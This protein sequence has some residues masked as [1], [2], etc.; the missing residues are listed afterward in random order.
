M[1]KLKKIGNKTWLILQYW[2]E[3][4]EFNLVTKTLSF[5]FSGLPEHNLMDYS[6]VLHLWR[7]WITFQNF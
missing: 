4:L 1:Q 2:Y 3:N 6:T 5:K 7:L